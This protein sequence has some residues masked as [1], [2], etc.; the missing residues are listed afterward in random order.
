MTHFL[1]PPARFILC[2]QWKFVSSKCLFSHHFMVSSLK[3]SRLIFTPL[4][5]TLAL[6]SNI[7]TPFISSPSSQVPFFSITYHYHLRHN[8]PH[9]HTIFFFYIWY[10]NAVTT[11]KTNL[12]PQQYHFQVHSATSPQQKHINISVRFL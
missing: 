8:S 5:P 12:Y 11:F 4:C 10:S 2:F 1:Q 9:T 3:N 7:Y 6:A